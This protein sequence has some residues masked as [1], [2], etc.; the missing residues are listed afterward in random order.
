MPCAA[1]VMEGAASCACSCT[2]RPGAL[3][4]TAWQGWHSAP[5]PQCTEHSH[6][7]HK[8]EEG[9]RSILLK[10]LDIQTISRLN[11]VTTAVSSPRNRL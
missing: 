10:P 1:P 7:F 3:G 5:A 2:S 11:R 9:L 8:C 6:L 4:G